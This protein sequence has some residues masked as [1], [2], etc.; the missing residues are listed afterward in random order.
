[1]TDKVVCCCCQVITT[2]KVPV[3]LQYV[4]HLDQVWAVCWNDISG[5]GTRSVIVIREASKSK[6]HGIVHPQSVAGGLDQVRAK[7]KNMFKI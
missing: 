2:D 1:M 7:S 6:R 4:S 3:S 5:T